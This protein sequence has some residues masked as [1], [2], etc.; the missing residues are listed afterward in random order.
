[1]KFHSTAYQVIGGYTFL[2][3]TWEWLGDEARKSK[4]GGSGGL[5]FVIACAGYE[6]WLDDLC[7]R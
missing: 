6:C 4:G 1:M 2:C 7:T 5:G 3:V